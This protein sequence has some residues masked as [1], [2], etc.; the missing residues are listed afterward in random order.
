MD[1]IDLPRPLESYFSLRELAA[2]HEAR[3]FQL[4]FAYEVGREIEHR[5]HEWQVAHTSGVADSSELESHFRRAVAQFQ[6][7]IRCWLTESKLRLVQG[8]EL[9]MLAPVE[10]GA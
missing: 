10:D 8:N 7:D 9:P 5:R 1:C 4:V 6:H 3:R 2:T